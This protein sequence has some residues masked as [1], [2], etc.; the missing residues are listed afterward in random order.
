MNFV[1]R[2]VQLEVLKILELLLGVSEDLGFCAQ[3]RSAD[4]GLGLAGFG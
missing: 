1:E 4:T 3:D 2:Q